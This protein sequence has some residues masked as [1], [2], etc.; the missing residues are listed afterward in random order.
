[1]ISKSLAVMGVLTLLSAA[2]HA[3][4]A[5]KELF[6]KSISVAWTETI[7]QR[8]ESDQRVTNVGASRQMSVYISTAGRPFVRLIE[9]GFG[10]YRYDGTS[11][12]RPSLTETAPGEAAEDRVDFEGRS[13][14]V[15]KQFRSGARRIAIDVDGTTC[16]AMIVHGREGGKIFR[17]RSGAA[18][19]KYCRYKLDP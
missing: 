13:I 8:V 16:R 6:G 11:A 14:V 18:E 2:A 12:S 10:G 1:M 3:G 7:T 17:G 4:S 5:P 15:Y 19:P 9:A